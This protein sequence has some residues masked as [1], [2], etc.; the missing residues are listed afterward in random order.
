MYSWTD[1]KALPV[2]TLIGTSAPGTN[3]APTAPT[4]AGGSDKTT[5]DDTTTPVS[6]KD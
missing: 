5:T 6:D 1:S 2:E 3:G 4:A